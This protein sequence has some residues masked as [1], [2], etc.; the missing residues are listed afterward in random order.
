MD[1]LLT[2]VFDILTYLF[3]LASTSSHFVYI[4]FIHSH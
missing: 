4:F 3:M 2:L 1:S